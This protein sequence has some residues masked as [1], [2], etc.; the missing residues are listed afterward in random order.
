[1]KIQTKKSLYVRNS[2]FAILN[3][4]KSAL[5]HAKKHKSSTSFLYFLPK[6]S[7]INHIHNTKNIQKT[8]KK[9]K[10]YEGAHGVEPWTSRSAVECS[11]TELY[12]R[13]ERN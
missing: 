6:I 4:S 2:D 9:A 5:T 13:D 10:N 12:P 1:M 7:H 11:T 3:S 8:S